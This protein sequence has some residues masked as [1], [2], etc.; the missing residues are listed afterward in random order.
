MLLMIS[1]FFGCS[2]DSPAAST[3]TPAP[4]VD[5]IYSG[6]NNPAPSTVSFTSTTTN[7]T[8]YLWD[9]GDNSSSTSANP[10]HL[11]TAGGVYTVKLTVSGAGGTTSTIKTV[12]IGAAL[13][14]VKISKVTIVNIP[15]TKPGGTSGWDLD[16][17]GPDIYFQIQDQNS[18]VL[19]DATS[20]NRFSDVT[21]SMLPFAWNISNPFVIT[22]LTQSRYIELFDYDFG[23]SDEDMGYVGFLM[24]N[25]TTGSNAYPTTVTQTNTTYGITVKLDLIWY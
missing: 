13:T 23:T 25:Y 15:F 14:H 6:A 21:P 1:L 3:S 24:S 20:S 8:N 5:F 19:F 7:A 4:T 22:D 17:S 10:Q 12:N 16:G 2:K 18:A 9:F 11:Y